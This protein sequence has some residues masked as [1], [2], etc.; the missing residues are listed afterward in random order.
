MTNSTD[1]SVRE[2]FDSIVVIPTLNEAQH[3]GAVLDALSDDA[4]PPEIWVVDGGSVDGTI[5]IVKERSATDPRIWLMD[6]PDR[7]QASALNLAASEAARRGGIE[8]IIRADA[9]AHYPAGWVR[10]LIETARE[11]AVDSVVVPMNTLGGGAVRNAAADL[12]NS[13][14]GNGGS[15]HRRTGEGGFVEHGHHAFFRLDS[16]LAAGGYDP[17]FVANEDA[18]LD[19]RLSSRGG[20]IYLEPRA[21]I[22]YLP[23]N[24]LGGVIRQFYRNGRYRIRTSRKHKA[25]LGLRQSAP[26]L[27]FAGVLVFVTA[28][29]LVHPAFL[30]APASYLVAV[31]VAAAAVASEKTPLRVCL[32]AAQAV[33][34]HLSFG[35]GALRTLIEPARNTETASPTPVGAS[36]SPQN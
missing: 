1:Y 24:T 36:A 26:I 31:L 30:A 21:T 13:W 6:N 15:P 33:L 4:A 11:K 22:G 18:E 12:F 20:R 34:A 16:F 10:R 29:A 35:A 32:I 25:A 19:M 23:R 28:G 9:H 27:L 2:Q 7:T 17:A 14:L 8:Y 3:I 5:D